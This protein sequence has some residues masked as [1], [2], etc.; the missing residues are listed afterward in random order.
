MSSLTSVR[1][2]RHHPAIFTT[3]LQPDESPLLSPT[4]F[5]LCLAITEQPL[6]LHTTC[7]DFPA[8]PTSFASFLTP[9]APCRSSPNS[10]QHQSASAAPT[11][12]HAVHQAHVESPFSSRADFF[13]F[14]HGLKLAQRTSSLSCSSRSYCLG[15]PLNLPPNSIQPCSFF[16]RVHPLITPSRRA[17]AQS[18]LHRT[19]AA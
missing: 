11:S 12:R 2:P 16:L 6:L 3:L 18:R 19:P 10:S 5:H 9:A 14:V 13:L 7:S 1:A 4:S 15:A 17:L 8:S